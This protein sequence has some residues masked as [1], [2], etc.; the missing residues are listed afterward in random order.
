[1][2]PETRSAILTA[3]VIFGPG[4]LFVGLLEVCVP[5]ILAHVESGRRETCVAMLTQ[6]DQAMKSYQLDHGPILPG[7]MAIPGMKAPVLDPWGR[8]FVFRHVRTISG[9]YGSP[10]KVLTWHEFRIHSVGPNGIDEAGQGDDIS[11]GS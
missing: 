5:I 10:P 11:W 8:P 9:N 6:L 7:A 1:M 3:A 2:K 4:T